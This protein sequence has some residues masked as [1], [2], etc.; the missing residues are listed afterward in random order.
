[1]RLGERAAERL[2][3]FRRCEDRLPAASIDVNHPLVA[4]AV[5]VGFDLRVVAVAEQDQIA[6]ELLICHVWRSR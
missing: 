3:P 1:M 5:L 6:Y 4:Y 2:H